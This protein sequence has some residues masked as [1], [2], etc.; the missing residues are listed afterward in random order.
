MDI[1]NKNEENQSV[2]ELAQC[3]GGFGLGISFSGISGIFQTS[4]VVTKLRAALQK[5]HIDSSLPLGTEDGHL[6]RI[7][8]S[9]MCRLHQ[10]HR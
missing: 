9:T 8:R 3:M 1:D 7:E 2:G 5:A 10:T 4:E 6:E